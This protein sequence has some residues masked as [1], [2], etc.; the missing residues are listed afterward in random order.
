MDEGGDK[1]TL[2][3]K[4]DSAKREQQIVALKLRGIPTPDIARVVGV[5]QR[6]VQAGFKKALR[7]QT[8]EALDAWHQAELG[9]LAM[10][11]TNIWRLMDI[12]ENKSDWRAQAGLEDRL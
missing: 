7:R 6:A 12:P 5:S 10:E 2:G 11:E 1:R 9:K 3:A 8:E 4:A